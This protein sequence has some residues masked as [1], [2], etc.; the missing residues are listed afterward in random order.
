MSYFHPNAPH[1]RAIG[2]IVALHRYSVQ[3]PHADRPRF[4]SFLTFSDHQ[5]SN[6]NARTVAQVVANLNFERNFNEFLDFLWNFFKLFP[7]LTS[8]NEKG[9]PIDSMKLEYIFADDLHLKWPIF[10]ELYEYFFYQSF[11]SWLIYAK[12]EVLSKCLTFGSG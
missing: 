7:V 5:Q 12:P 6:V 9:W 11:S 1:L 2:N 4:S 8:C 3:R 10:C